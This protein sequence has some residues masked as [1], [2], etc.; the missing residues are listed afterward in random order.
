MRK[1]SFLAIFL[2]LLFVAPANNGHSPFVNPASTHSPYESDGD[3]PFGFLAGDSMSGSGDPLSTYVSGILENSSETQIDSST[4]VTGSLS[5]PSGYSGTSLDVGIDSLSMT[6]TDNLRNPSFTTWHD[7]RWHVG[8]SINFYDDNI[9]V[10]DSW[11]LVKS[12][13]YDDAHPLHGDWELN[14]YSGGYGGSRAWRFEAT[15]GGSD[16]LTPDDAIYLS[17]FLH[18]PW[19]DLYEIRISFYYYVLSTSNMLDQVH[20]FF[21]LGDLAEEKFHV[22]Q[23]GDTTDAWLQETVTYTSA[24]LSSVTVPDSLLFN[25]GLATDVSGTLGTYQAAFVYVDEVK[26][27]M[28]VRPYPEQIGLNANNTAVVGSIAGNISTFVPDNDGRDCWDYSN[29]GIDLDGYNNDGRP[30]WGLWGTFWNTSEPYELGLQFPLDI[31]KGAVIENAYVEIQSA[32]GSGVVHGRVHLSSEMAAGGAIESFADHEQNYEHLEDTY[33]W[34]AASYDWQLTAWGNGVRYATPD[35]SPLLQNVVSSS[36]WS[37]GQY[38]AV[39]VSY[40]WSSYYQYYN[41]IRGSLYDTNDADDNARLYVS[42]RVPL[43]EDVVLVDRE[44]ARRTLKYKKGITVD[45]TKVAADLT[46]F[47]LLI[48]II[49]TDLH[50]DVFPGGDDIAFMV[51]GQF[52]EHEI[53]FFDQNH[54]PTEA[55]LVAWVKVPF[56][57]SSTDTIITMLYGGSDA[58]SL[59]TK[60]VFADYEIVH[61]MNE[62]PN[63]TLVDSSGNLHYGYSIGGMTD[64][65]SVAGAIGS[66]INFDGSDDAIT[67]GQ[68]DT[69]EWPSFTVT[70]WVSQ[71]VVGD[72]RIFSKAPNTDGTQAIIHFAINGATAFRVRMNTDGT[73]G[74]ASGSVDSTTLTVP[75]NWVYLAWSWSAATASMRLYV[76]GTFDRSVARD[77]DTVLDSILPFV[78]G[79]WQTGPYD[80]RF[81]DGKIDEIRMTQ[82]VLSDGWIET[83]FNN[84]LDP[85]TF[86][87]MGSEQSNAATPDV[88]YTSV[89]FTTGSSIPVNL[90]FTLALDF[91]GFGKSLDEN[92]NEG[93]TFHAVNDSSTVTWIAKVLVAPLPN[94]AKMEVQ[95]SYPMTEWRPTSVTNP[96]GVSKSYLTDWT[97]TGG[98]LTLLPAAVDVYG[99]WILEFEGLNYLSDLQ[100]GV[101]GGSLS[102]TAEFQTNHTMQ[103]EGTSLWHAGSAT[104]LYLTDPTGSAWSTP[105]THNT[106]GSDTHEI[107]SFQYRKVITIDNAKVY[108]DVANFPFL[109]DITDANVDDR[110][111]ADGDDILFV[112]NGVVIPHDLVEY[113]VAAGSAHVL[114]WVQG[115]LSNLVDTDITMYYGNSIVGP[116][117]QPAAV[118]GEEY[119]GVY[120]LEESPTGATG[121]IIDSTTYGNDGTTE[122]SMNSADLVDAMFGKGLDFDEIDDMIR[123]KDDASLDTVATAGTIQLWIWWDNASDGQWQNIMDSSN[124]FNGNPNDGFEWAQQ[125]DGDHFFYPWAGVGSDYNLGTNPFTN[126]QWHHLAVTLNYTS[127]PKSV[128]MYVDGSAIPIVIPNVP[129]FWTQIA[130]PGD[131]QW[132]GDPDYPDRYF[133]GMFDEIRIA[134]VER[135]AG[136]LFTEFVN[137]DNPTAFYNNI[138]LEQSRQ[139]YNS[140]FVKALDDTA[141]AGIWTVTALFNDSGSAVDYSV[142][143]YER[144][145]IVKHDTSLILQEPSDAVG[146]RLTVTTAG[147]WIYVEYELTD[148]ITAAGVPD[149]TVTLNWT[150]SGAPTQIILDDFGT[151]TYGKMLNT[152]NLG[153]AQR[154][155]VNLQS[156]HQ[157]YNDA[158]EYINVDLYHQTNLDYGDV[159]TTPA[160]VDFTATLT[161]TDIYDGSP[162][163]GAEITLDGSPVTHNDLGQGRYS[164]SIPTGALSL[165]QHWY[166]FNATLTGSYLEMASVN[167]TFTLRQHFTSVNIQGDLVQPY[168]FDTQFDVIFLDLDTG[169]AVPLSAVSQFS[170]DPASY[171]IQTRP[172]TSYSITLTTNTWDVATESVTL[173]LTMADTKYAIPQAYLFDIAIRARFT[174]VSVSGSF[175]QPHGNMTPL[176]VYLWDHDAEEVVPIGFVDGL[177]FTWPGD[178]QAILSPSSYNVVLDTSTWD[179]GT[180]TVTLIANLPGA[181]YLNPSNFVFDITI[182]SMSTVLYHDPSDLVFAEGSDFWI[183]LR[184]N[185]SEAGASFGEPVTGLTQGEFSLRG[186]PYPFTIDTTDNL[187]GRYR[188]TISYANL[189]PGAFT[190]TVIVTPSD[191]SHG[192]AQVTIQFFYAEVQTSL[193]SP[194]HPQVTTP[195]ATDVQLT[196]NYTDIESGLGIPGATITNTSINIYGLVDQGAGIY[197]LWLDVTGFAEGSHAFT[198]GA[199]KVGYESRSLSFTVLIRIAYTYA[200]PS[201]GALDIPIGNSPIFY[202]DYWDIDH[203]APVD[204]SSAPYTRVLSTWHNFTVVYIPAQERY[205]ITFMTSDSDSL[206]TNIVYTFNFSRGSNYQFGIFNITVSI[207]T[208]N[209]DFRLVSAIEPTSNVGIINISVYYGDLDNNFGVDSVNVAFSVENASGSVISSSL[210]LGGGFYIIQIAANQFG[211]GVQ[212][213]TVYA[214]WMG[215]FAKYQN[216]DFTTTASVVGLESALTLLQASAPTPYLD[217]MS[218]LF[219]YSELSGVGIDNLTSNVFIHVSFQGE[220]VDLDQVSIYDYSITQP[221]NYSIQLNTSIFDRTGIIY[222]NVFVNWTK[223]VAPFYQNRTD[224]VTLRILPRDTLVSVS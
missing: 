18:A 123:I 191:A 187:I 67:V 118:W 2:V 45:Y 126:Q 63:G 185:V 171:G 59:E 143:I 22:F 151:G 104:Q 62:A 147:E 105:I 74:G 216:K 173:T 176:S 125:N 73:G 76:N 133:D 50:T 223:G 57:S 138:G 83:E 183:D 115:N 42:Y 43:A 52:V 34:L 60:G 113:T 103:F 99:V 4:S 24:D 129:I 180:T 182:R 166:I 169:G 145:F 114:A 215:P 163:V 194:T 95:I 15:I 160:D 47:P 56:L 41:N 212:T 79:N 26:I 68:I 140:T 107:P 175:V 116:Q 84:Q 20:L 219:F 152:N 221:G 142:G 96:I 7:E 78:I 159:T 89:Q 100:L 82:M 195:F 46:D 17:Q 98:V 86:Y 109:L 110:A 131:W 13:N 101:F 48:D 207:R 184:V 1:G 80:N 149:A 209:T 124:R 25:I 161:F 202:V 150:V 170:F 9:D 27:E 222:M 208:H 153:T 134:N 93:T 112:Q 136:W 70:G 44:E 69:D 122:G 31:P 32:G 224:V 158:T 37:S 97:Y 192:R 189:G 81:F 92:F 146:D 135:S 179:V 155:R 127:S 91:E 167:I 162:I 87:S 165:G 211:L 8:N 51:D 29:L 141:A 205:Q 39:M 148:D 157:F 139:T 33:S 132:G 72:D 108:D 85:S 61:H 5:V 65:Q 168:G 177:I 203:D 174:S 204:N 10:P 154:W 64:T 75:G 164:V 11:T 186:N 40:M 121:E 38:I 119:V 53:E 106:A 88:T 210:S 172:G 16:S 30:E 178:S 197:T 144:E 58:R 200:I 55:H 3:T 217:N 181:E 6:V 188:L 137:Q 220:S 128:K 77:G 14:D 28:D 218:F 66:S 12:V 23:P 90:G 214:D 19:R 94:V 130:N 190:I 36:D 117:E 206:Q 201:V 71:D 196:L 199:D 198:L 193:T 102:S 156:T 111:Q 21:K 54:S 120:H 35:I 49:D 213:F